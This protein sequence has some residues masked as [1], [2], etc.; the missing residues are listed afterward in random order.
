MQTQSRIARL[1]RTHTHLYAK[2]YLI[3]L[4]AETNSIVHTLLYTY[5]AHEQDTCWLILLSLLFGT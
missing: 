5:L 4:E 2:Q 3:K 1:R